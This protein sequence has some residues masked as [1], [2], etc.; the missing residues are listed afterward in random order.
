MHFSVVQHSWLFAVSQ[1][2]SKLLAVC[3]DFYTGASMQKSPHLHLTLQERPAAPLVAAT[4]AVLALVPVPLC[5][6]VCS[7]CPDRMYWC[8]QEASSHGRWPLWCSRRPSQSR[9]PEPLLV[10]G[11]TC[12]QPAMTM[13]TAGRGSMQATLWGPASGG[14]GLLLRVSLQPTPLLTAPVA[15]HSTLAVDSL[16]AG[17]M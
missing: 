17:L 4:P 1:P 6:H 5:R 14:A 8:L 11:S 16:R 12:L 10:G 3:L 9:P 13:M 2:F 15:V 7:S